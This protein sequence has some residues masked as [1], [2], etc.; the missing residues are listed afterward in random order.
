[1][2]FDTAFEKGEIITSETI[3]KEFTSVFLRK[4]FD[5]YLSFS[6]RLQLVEFIETQLLLWPSELIKPLHASR[7]P[8]DNMFL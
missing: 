3:T 8:K 5:K 7:D 2:A 6:K 4:K 1:M